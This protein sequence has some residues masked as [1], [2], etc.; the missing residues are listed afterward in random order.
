MHQAN[1]FRSILDSAEAPTGDGAWRTLGLEPENFD[2]SLSDIA[3]ELLEMTLKRSVEDGGVGHRLFYDLT[4]GLILEN[5]V[6]V[7]RW[8]RCSGI[9]RRSPTGC[10]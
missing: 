3:K 1:A 5:L 4:K 9:S 10:L 6:R 2:G 8:K 7:G